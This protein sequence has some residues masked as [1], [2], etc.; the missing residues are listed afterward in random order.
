M[1]TLYV[2]DDWL[3]F[4][5]SEYGGLHVVIADDD[6]QVLKMLADPKA[7]N[8]RYADRNDE[9]NA[10]RKHRDPIRAKIAQAQRFVVQS[11]VSRIVRSF[12]T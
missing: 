10:D 9:T 7:K 2:I 1:K 8:R 3:T 11:D 5:E 12:S 6:A 4:P